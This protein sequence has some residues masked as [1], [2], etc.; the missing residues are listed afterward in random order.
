MS[1]DYF[2]KD[3]VEY[4][5]SKLKTIIDKKQ[6]K[7]IP[8]DGISI[9]PDTDIISINGGSFG[10]TDYAEL[11]NKPSINNIKLIGN[12]TGSDLELAS[13]NDVDVKTDA[14]FSSNFTMELLN[15]KMNN[16][17]IVFADEFE[18]ERIVTNLFKEGGNN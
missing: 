16:D 1:F 14:C 13:I 18:I 15:K 7:L 11:D 17:A 8:G 9:N 4:I 5:L 3:R 6:N 2:S 12:M 10:T